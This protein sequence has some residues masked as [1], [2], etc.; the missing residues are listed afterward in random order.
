MQV[1][2]PKN[3]K[4]VATRDWEKMGSDIGE[5]GL[6][7]D[8]EQPLPTNVMYPGVC[9]CPCAHAFCALRERRWHIALESTIDC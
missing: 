3:D 5:L 9:F 8:D 7:D 6:F 4:A 2:E 1:L